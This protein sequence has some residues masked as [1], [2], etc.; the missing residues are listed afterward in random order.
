MIQYVGK[1]F[2]GVFRPALLVMAE[3]LIWR[4]FTEQRG[5]TYSYQPAYGTSLLILISLGLLAATFKAITLA[6]K[7]TLGDEW[8]Y[9]WSPGNIVVIFGILIHDLPFS[10]IIYFFYIKFYSVL[11]AFQLTLM[12]FQG[13]TVIIGIGCK[14][15]IIRCSFLF[16]SCEL[17][18]RPKVSEASTGGEH[19]TQKVGGNLDW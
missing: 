9:P 15:Y 8:S 13:K 3:T 16:S 7:M 18:T 17:D 2:I 12:V 1:W 4:S 5:L 11:S 19:G 6:K 14:L 10:F